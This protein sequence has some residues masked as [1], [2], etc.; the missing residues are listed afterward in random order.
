MPN[1]VSVPAAA[2]QQGAKGPF[3]YV[4]KAD[5]TASLRQVHTGPTH[6]ERTQIL[7]GVDEGE[8]VIT[9]GVDRLREG[10]KINVIQPGLPQAED[11]EHDAR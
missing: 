8:R 10:A 4:A 5:S 6:L 2:V 11:Q 1:A 9:E 3:V 7:E